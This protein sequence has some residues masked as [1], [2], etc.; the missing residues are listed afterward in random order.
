MTQAA[1]I[2][3]APL[4]FNSAQQAVLD[5]LMDL[6]IP[7]SQDG[8]MPA[9]RALRLFGSGTPMRAADR[10]LFEQGLAALDAQAQQA[11]G[12][13]FAQ[14]GTAQA[15]ALVDTLRAENP[16]FVQSVVTQTVG[17]YLAHP[18]VMPLLGLEARPPWPQGN[19]VA[20]GDW[21]MLDVVKRREKIYRKV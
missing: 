16:A 3:T 12:A 17:R 5:V 13:S 21:S 20:E 4:P 6:L 10:T 19:V 9:A 15:K 1:Q 11:H 14:L 2:S 8:R 7:A 18:M